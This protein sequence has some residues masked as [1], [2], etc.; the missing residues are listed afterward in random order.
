VLSVEVRTFIS[1]PREDV[2]DLIVDMAARPAWAGDVMQDLRLTTPR[3]SGVGA[4]ARYRVTVPLLQQWAETTIA[5]AER[6]RLVVEQGRSGRIGRNRTGA[7]WEL[8]PEAGGVTR[9]D[10]LFWLEPAT[11]IERLR[12]GFGAQRRMRRRYRR[13]LA[14][15]RRLLEE[16]PDGPLPR[17]TIAAFEPMKAPR[18]G[19]VPRLRR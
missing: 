9:V 11:A 1:A 7:T 17:A 15:L 18:F 13:A 5:E 12:E 8:T 10:L 19:A 4:G 3:S 2:F 16:G 6:P 14:R